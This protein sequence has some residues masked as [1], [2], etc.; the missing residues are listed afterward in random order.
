MC[1]KREMGSAFVLIV[2]NALGTFGTIK[3]NYVDHYWARGIV[4]SRACVINNMFH[5][6]CIAGALRDVVSRDV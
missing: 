4:A 3:E 2:G 1:R 6:S 5:V